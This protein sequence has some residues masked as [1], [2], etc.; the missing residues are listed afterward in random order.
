M[1]QTCDRVTGTWKGHYP[2]VNRR[3]REI[4]PGIHE[5]LCGDIARFH[6]E[7]SRD[8]LEIRNTCARCLSVAIES[9]CGPVT[10]TCV[11]AL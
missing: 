8:G 6:L 2:E 5:V 10:V 9:Y 7:D 1:D 3:G 11:K 4:Q